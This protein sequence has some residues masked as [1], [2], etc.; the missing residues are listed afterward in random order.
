MCGNARGRSS[1]SSASSSATRPV[2]RRCS[3]RSGSRSSIRS[4]TMRAGPPT[5]IRAMTRSTRMRP[6]TGEHGSGGPLLRGEH[7]QCP[8]LT[9]VRVLVTGGAG[10]IGSHLVDALVG[11][12]AEVTVL[13]NLV[14]GRASNLDGPARLVE[15]SIL[16]ADLVDKEVE[17]ADE[18]FHLAAAVGVRHIVDDPLGSLRTNTRGTEHVL[19]ACARHGRRI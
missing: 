7:D 14:T 18:V 3:N 19:D 1:S 12:G 13:D 4:A 15:G 5:F 2:S 11:E 6:G 10:F 16:D 9:L 8:T 17:A